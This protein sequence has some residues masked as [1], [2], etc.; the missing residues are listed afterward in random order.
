MDRQTKRKAT[1][2]T[3]NFVFQVDWISH[4]PKADESHGIPSIA[5]ADSML[6]E[7]TYEDF[8]ILGDTAVRES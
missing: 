4:I 2:T 8:E 1:P 6:Q 7:G 3:L 5:P